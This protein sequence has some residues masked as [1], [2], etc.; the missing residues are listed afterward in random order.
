M[1]IDDRGAEFAKMAGRLSSALPS[2]AETSSISNQ[3]K[4]EVEFPP[5]QLFNLWQKSPIYSPLPGRKR[6]KWQPTVGGRVCKHG[7]P[8]AFRS[9]LSGENAFST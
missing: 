4:R 3:L 7:R 6:E 2:L 1:E 9:S 8:A 5:T